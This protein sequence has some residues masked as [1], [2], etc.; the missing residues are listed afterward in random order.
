MHRAELA[1]DGRTE[2][3]D[4][5]V[6][7]F[8]EQGAVTLQSDLLAGRAPLVAPAVVIARLHAQPVVPALLDVDVAGRRGRALVSAI[9]VRQRPYVAV[10]GLFT[11]ALQRNA[12]RM[13][14][15]LV[16]VWFFGVGLTALAGYLLARRALA[17]V[18]R[19]TAQAR[20][21]AHG[22]LTAH[23]EPPTVDD[24]IGRMTRLL[25]E[26]LDELH[27]VIA[28]NRRFASDA[29]HELRTPL[30][31]LAGEID[32]A[33]RRERTPAEYRETLRLLRAGLDEMTDLTNN[34][35]LLVRAEERHTDTAVEIVPLRDLVAASFRRVAALARERGIRCEQAGAESIGVRSAPA[36]LAR[37][38]DNVII[39]AVRYNRE[40]GGVLVHA[41]YSPPSPED[42]QGTV[43]IRVVD[44]GTG[45][46]ETEW[47][48]V[49][50]R[51]YRL[52]PSRSRGT[53]GS[54]IGLSI[55]RAIAR[56]F[57][58]TI[59]VDV[60]GPRGTTFLITLPGGPLADAPDDAALAADA[61]DVVSAGDAAR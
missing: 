46:P 11:D 47:E 30:A 20:R 28:S 2:E 16:G 43:S 29:A 12:R 21:I 34:L 27:R 14:S 25:N 26:M 51:F 35:I 49:F 5:F 54:G 32:V 7:F 60:S 6:Q 33:L 18:D 10:I 8:D 40:G 36:L 37:L 13:A 48:R 59:R 41:S 52:E 42:P 44:T 15:L 4:K 22:Q 23:L 9:V 50:D 56:L 31:A 55:S 17:P 1:R 38:L 61:H 3:I 57:G 45:I 53:G 58:G 39:N 19:I 24:E